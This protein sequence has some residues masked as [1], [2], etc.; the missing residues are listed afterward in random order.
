MN[1]PHAVITLVQYDEFKKCKDSHESNRAKIV[2]L[3]NENEKLKR[4]ID[5]F[6]N[7][8]LYNDLNHALL[9]QGVYMSW[10]NQLKKAIFNFK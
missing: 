5:N 7:K 2:Q 4:A 6:E 10:D 3:E 9:E 1:E 8:A